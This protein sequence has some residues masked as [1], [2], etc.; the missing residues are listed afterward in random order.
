MT[1]EWKTTRDVLMAIA[2]EYHRTLEQCCH[3][4]VKYIR[5]RRYGDLPDDN[6]RAALDELEALP[7]NPLE[8][9][10]IQI[11][12]WLRSQPAELLL[13]PARKYAQ[14]VRDSG[15]PPPL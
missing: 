4:F 11:D 8:A 6:A 9:S 7:L 1:D 12:R 13:E 10:A 14:D 3:S 2:I 15:N 5:D